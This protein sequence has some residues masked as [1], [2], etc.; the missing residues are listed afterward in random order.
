MTYMKF[1][2]NH[3]MSLSKQQQVYGNLMSYKIYVRPAA[4][5]LYGYA[6]G[7]VSKHQKNVHTLLHALFVYGSGTTWDMARTRLRSVADIREQEKIYRRLL[8]GRTDRGKYSG[9]VLNAGLVISERDTKKP[10]TM[11][12]LSLHGI[13]YCIDALEPT[14]KE[15]D[16]MATQYAF[17]LPKVFGNWKYIRRTLEQDAYCLRI[18]AK[19]LYLDNAMM[20]RSDIPLYEL[21]SF[22]HTKYRKNFE[23]MSEYDLSEQISYWFYTFLLYQNHTEKLRKVLAQ[24]KQLQ[25]WYMNFFRQT[26]DYY[27]ERL[28]I[29]KNSS[30]IFAF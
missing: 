28:S 9:G 15:M 30:D 2:T 14:K 27:A 12:R 6:T 1:I 3:G 22:I 24:D 20:V 19:G 13:L 21:M 18:L 11:Y 10:Y 7:T 25:K 29:L 8:V 23:S 4:R 5:N 16:N 26:R 17:L